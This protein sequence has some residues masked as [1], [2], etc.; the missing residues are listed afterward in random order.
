L[1][2]EVEVIYCDCFQ[3]F[4]EKENFFGKDTDRFLAKILSGISNVCNAYT[5]LTKINLF[6]KFLVVHRIKLVI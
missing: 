3:T 1:K 2:K 5:L 6:V 4:V